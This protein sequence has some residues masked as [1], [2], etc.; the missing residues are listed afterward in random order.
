MDTPSRFFHFSLA[1][2][3][4]RMRKSTFPVQHGISSSTA[5]LLW[6]AAPALSGS[7]TAFSRPSIGFH[8]FNPA[9][10][11]ELWVAIKLIAFGVLLLILKFRS[12]PTPAMAW[13]ANADTRFPRHDA[14]EENHSHNSGNHPEARDGIKML[15]TGEPHHWRTGQKIN[16]HGSLQ[17]RQAPARISHHHE[18]AEHRADTK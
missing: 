15:R 8:R 11:A 12:Q 13:W 14:G 1:P 7:S 2:S 10:L 3:K 9:L 5:C 17:P 4:Y 18:Y 6:E 16:P